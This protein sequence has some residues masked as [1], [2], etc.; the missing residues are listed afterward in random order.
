[1]KILVNSSDQNIV[2]NPTQDFKSDLGWQENMSIMEREI[3]EDIINPAENY[4]TIRYSHDSYTSNNDVNQRDIW[5]YFNF[6]DNS[7][8]YTNGLT[9]ANVG[10]TYR[11]NANMVPLAVNSFF[12]LE[13]YKTYNNEPPTHGNRKLV[14]SKNLNF[15]TGQKTFYN[16]VNDT[17]YVPEFMGSEFINTENMYFFWFLDDSAFSETNITG[18]TFYM[19]AKFY[20]AV[21]GNIID[22]VNKSLNTSQY[23]TEENDLYY[24]VVI[25]RTDYSYQIFEFNGSVGN[26]VGTVDNPIHF[27]QKRV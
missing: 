8:G 9:Y 18:N 2:L 27:Y 21:D 10:I 1:M 5:Y 25:D 6:L 19:T 20:N 14:F 17:V 23:V 22:F 3:L 26:R 12:R 13:F 15:A 16:V 24:K 4:E 11:E 7:N